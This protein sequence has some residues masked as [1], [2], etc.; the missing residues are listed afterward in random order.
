MSVGAHVP[1]MTIASVKKSGAIAVASKV[2]YRDVCV[3]LELSVK[4]TCDPVIVTVHGVPFS[5]ACGMVTFQ[6]YVLVPSPVVV[7][8]K[9]F[10]FTL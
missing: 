7:K 5:S 9:V 8:L 6:K 2:K 3:P 4:L 1:L 10:S